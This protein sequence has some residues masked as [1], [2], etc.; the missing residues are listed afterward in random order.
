MISGVMVERSCFSLCCTILA[1]AEEARMVR[2]KM[3]MDK[4]VKTHVGRDARREVLL[5]H[6]MVAVESG[7]WMWV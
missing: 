7:C 4:R 1:K 6:D 2:V 3:S 5:E